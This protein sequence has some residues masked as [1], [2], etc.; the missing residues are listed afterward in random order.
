MTARHISVAQTNRAAT[1]ISL[2]EKHCRYSIHVLPK[3]LN[4]G[5]LNEQT[6]LGPWDTITDKSP[7]TLHRTYSEISYWYLSHSKRV[8]ECKRLCLIKTLLQQHSLSFKAVMFQCP[9]LSEPRYPHRAP[10]GVWELKTFE[11][12]QQTKESRHGDTSPIATLSQ[13]SFQVKQLQ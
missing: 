12:K 3:M 13:F 2:Q 4:G 11:T 7:Q 6:A 5:C 10:R 8:T 1:C 9:G